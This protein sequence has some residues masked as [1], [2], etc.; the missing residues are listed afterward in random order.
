[1]I[2]N[3]TTA[4]IVYFLVIDPVGTTPIFFTL[5]THLKKR[6]KIRAALESSSVAGAPILFFAVYGVWILHYAIH[7]LAHTTLLVA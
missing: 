6:Q 2:K 5:T 3:I 1:M 7:R 4:F